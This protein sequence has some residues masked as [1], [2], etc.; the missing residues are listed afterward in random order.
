MTEELGRRLFMAR[1]EF[2]LLAVN[3]ACYVTAA[4]ASAA[5]AAVT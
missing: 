2:W 5:S 1:R 4:L 3:D